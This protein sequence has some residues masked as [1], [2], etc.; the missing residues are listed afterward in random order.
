[1][2]GL[3]HVEANPGDVLLLAGTTK[4]AFD[5]RRHRIFDGLYWRAPP[6]DSRH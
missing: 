3:K 4:G 2:P 6:A 1:M 5:I